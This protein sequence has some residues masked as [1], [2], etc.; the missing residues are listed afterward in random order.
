MRDHV[1]IIGAGAGGL[2]AAI[3][4]SRAGH[5]VTLIDKFAR[6]GGKM[7][8][9]NVASQL[10]S[11]GPT[12]C[13]M[14]WVVDSLLAEGGLDP[15]TELVMK[16]APRLARHGWLDGT[17]LDLFADV[18]ASAAA[19]EA[20]FGAGEADGYLRFARD[21]AE[22]DSVLR[23]SFM[24][25]QKTGPLGLMRR[26]GFHRPQA[27]LKTSPF[28]SLSA[29]LRR[30]FKDPRLVQLFARYATYV[31]SS[32]YLAPATLKVI[33]HVEQEGVWLVEGG[34]PALAAALLRAAEAQGAMFIP[35]T[36]ADGILVSA[37][38]VT[39]VRLKTGER[40]MAD[41]VVFNGDPDALATGRLGPAARGAVPA[42]PR[43]R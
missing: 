19:I 28:N 40:L 7:R 34:M 6:P 4:L 32:P 25:A 2:A 33:A 26:I 16:R 10:I 13:T 8:Q 39:G 31:G 18:T 1:I 24:T 43:A 20:A 15:A 27:L 41:H 12:V 14:R 30:Y 29:D 11:N 37:G 23:E 17:R 36:E 35:D 22:T 5:R 3:R 38:R 42:R 9:V 21:A